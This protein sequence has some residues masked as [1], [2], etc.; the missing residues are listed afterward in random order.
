MNVL[1]STRKVV[2]QETEFFGAYG[3]AHV[4]VE[5]L[6]DEGRTLKYKEMIKLAAGAGVLK[7]AV[8][9]DVGCGSGILSMMV[10]NAGAKHVYCLERSDM[11]KTARAAVTF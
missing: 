8:V 7:N 11:A 3:N 2:E 5:M 4:H 10:A 6:L 1:P 9:L